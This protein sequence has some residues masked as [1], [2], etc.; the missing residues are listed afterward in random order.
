MWQSPPTLLSR[1]QV[2]RRLGLIA[3][4]ALLPACSRPK[5]YSQTEDG[6][7]RHTA[8]DVVEVWREAGLPVDDVQPRPIATATPDPDNRRAPRVSGAPPTEPMIEVEARNFH[9]PP[10]SSAPGKVIRGQIYVF[11]SAERLRA[12]RIWFARF[13]DLYPYVYTH[14]N[15][16]IKLDT[17]IGSEAAARY[18]AALETLP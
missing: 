12:K 16:L 9:I 15:I 18:R 8:D 3:L 5:R 2:S 4:A 11:D 6:F 7:L 1:R 14:A 17:A 13:P 10:A